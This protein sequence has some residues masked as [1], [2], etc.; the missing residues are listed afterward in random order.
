MSA[1]GEVVEEPTPVWCGHLYAACPQ[2]RGVLPRGGR[3][4]NGCRRRWLGRQ[5]RQCQRLA[6][7]G[8]DRCAQHAPRVPAQRDGHR[9]GES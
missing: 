4:R 7:P 5:E 6:A 1:A 2:C 9:D 3:C 8:S